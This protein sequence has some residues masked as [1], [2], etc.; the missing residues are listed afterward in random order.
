MYFKNVAEHVDFMERWKMT[1]RELEM[2]T[3]EHGAL[4]RALRPT[5]R[6]VDLPFSISVNSLGY[7][8]NRPF[9]SFLVP[10]F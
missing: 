1:A 6:I 9:P 8:D 7:S 10:L 3:N 4:Q 5:G 2:S